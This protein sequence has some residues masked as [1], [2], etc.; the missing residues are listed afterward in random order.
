M[1]GPCNL[2]GTF[3][4]G[5]C[6]SGPSFDVGLSIPLASGTTSVPLRT[7]SSEERASSRPPFSEGPACRVRLSTFDPPLGLRGHDKRAPPALRRDLPVRSVVRRW[8]MHSLA[9]GT[10]SVPLRSLAPTTPCARGIVWVT[11]CARGMV[12]AFVTGDRAAS[13]NP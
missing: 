6:L 9:S 4:G 2:G 8:I 3:S 7:I 1:N 5:T 11:H 13:H 12:S 10:T